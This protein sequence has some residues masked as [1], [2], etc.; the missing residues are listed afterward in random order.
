M[1]GESVV[2][3][4]FG[5]APLILQI[6]VQINLRSAAFAGGSFYMPGVRIG[7]CIKGFIDPPWGTMRSPISCVAIAKLP[8]YCLMP[9]QQ[10]RKHWAGTSIVALIATDKI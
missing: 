2:R 9:L 4:A 6:V 8:A 3:R 1:L 7:E 5:L 10:Y